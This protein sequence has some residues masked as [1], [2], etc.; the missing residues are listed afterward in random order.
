MA[1]RAWRHWC[2]GAT[3]FASCLALFA[4]FGLRAEAADSWQSI[5]KRVKSN[6]YQVNVAIKV[7][8][9]DGLNAQLADLSPR[10]RYPVFI[11]MKEDQGFRVIG[12]GTC[13]PVHSLK[14]DR[15]YMLTN[16]HVVDFGEGMLQECQRF[17]AAM[18][19]YA[20]RSAGF[21]SPDARYKDLMRI[22]NLC[23]KKEMSGAENSMYRA[24]VDTIWDVYDA[25]LSLKADPTRAAF[26]KCL[27]KT[28][29][30]GSVGFFIHSPGA[31]TQPP[32]VAD[33]Y[34]GARKQSDPDLAILA[35]NKKLSALDLDAAAA[36]QGQAIQA[37]G[38]PVAAKA[39]KG[40]TAQYAP[41]FSNG[42]IT[43]VTPSLVHFDASVSK[44]DSGGPL[45]SQNGKVIGV[46]VRRAMPD[47]STERFA[48]AISV[49]AVK[50]FAPE[51]F[52]ASK[53][54][55]RTGVRPH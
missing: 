15:T 48:G 35:V 6:V 31:V 11:T 40:K 54:T 7:K 53:Q 24:T 51:L 3:V 16:K 43:R 44:G 1:P 39:A 52:G 26:T 30:Q 10:L 36:R 29:F 32:M 22:V 42:K 14:N 12:H 47:I 4:A 46:V 8:L 49:K 50:S 37:V 2:A 9:K 34:R 28:G 19:L 18:R 55:G 13:F 21:A 25:H 23:A 33:L 17:F 20:E 38:Y 41:S 45:L 27:N 5:D